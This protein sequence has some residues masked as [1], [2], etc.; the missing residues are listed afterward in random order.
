MVVLLNRF[1]LCL[2]N[3]KK[4][5]NSNLVDIRGIF[6]VMYKYEQAKADI[7]EWYVIIVWGRI[8]ETINFEYR[9]VICMAKETISERQ[10]SYLE[11]KTWLV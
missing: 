8:A 9:T 3:R 6:P 7:N 2:Y 1:E 10:C 11:N 4:N 5:S